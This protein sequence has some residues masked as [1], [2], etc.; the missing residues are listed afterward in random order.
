MKTALRALCIALLAVLLGGSALAASYS[1]QVLPS[2]MPVYAAKSTSAA[3]Y[4]P[5]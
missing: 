1:A 4:S 5:L 2:S 3:R